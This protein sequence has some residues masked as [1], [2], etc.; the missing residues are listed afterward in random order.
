MLSKLKNK[1]FKDQDFFTPD[2]RQCLIIGNFN[3]Q[4]IRWTED[5]ADGNAVEK[6]FA[7]LN[8]VQDD[9]EV[10][11]RNIA[12]YGFGDTDILEKKNI[13]NK[14]IKKIFNE[15]QS[16]INNNAATNRKTL[17]IVYYAGHGMM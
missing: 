14:S 8:E 3:Y 4:A 17:T 2:I 7:D 12:E 10:F 11:S 15:Y 1:K 5:D 6:G 9:I 16:K 13:N